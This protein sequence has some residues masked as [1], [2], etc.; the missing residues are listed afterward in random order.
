[1]AHLLDEA[2]RQTLR[3]PAD[4]NATVLIASID[5]FVGEALYNGVDL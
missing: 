4:V 5:R 2:T 3:V 1:M